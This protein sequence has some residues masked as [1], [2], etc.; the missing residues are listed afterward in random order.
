MSKETKKKITLLDVQTAFGRQSPL[1]MNVA[2][3]KKPNPKEVPIVLTHAEQHFYK[4]IEVQFEKTKLELMQ[5]F[6][7]EKLTMQNSICKTI[8]IIA[9]ENRKLANN[10]MQMLVKKEMHIMVDNLNS[11][12]DRVQLAKIH[13]NQNQ[14]MS[15][16]VDI[17]ISFN[18]VLAE[19][20]LITDKLK[21]NVK[22]STFEVREIKIG[23]RSI[24]LNKH[25]QRLLNDTIE[26]YGENSKEY[27]AIKFQIIE[28][29]NQFEKNQPV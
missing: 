26:Q 9:K 10:E 5:H 21:K 24:N 13:P 18:K 16:L 7:E 3:A 22:A 12:L 14:I 23:D 2:Q 27:K 19:M 25:H 11:Y 15:K 1:T 17:N 4:H 8:Q 6:T 28:D 29:S 20:N